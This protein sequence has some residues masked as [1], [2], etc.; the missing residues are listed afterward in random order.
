M[1]EISTIEKIRENDALLAHRAASGDSAARRQVAE[2][3]F[4]RVRTR[5]WYL[6]SSDRD[7]DDIIQNSLIE[8][9]KSLHNFRGESTL[10]TWADRIVIRTAMRFFNNRKQKDPVFLEDPEGVIE[11]KA[12]QLLSGSEIKAA[13]QKLLVKLPE[14]QRVVCVMRFAGEYSM[15]EIADITG[16]PLNTVKDR[17]KTGKAKL[18]RMIQSDPVLSHWVKESDYVD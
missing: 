12:F 4:E 10:D 7:M 13:L 11:C 6:A 15:E 2:K 1:T 5:V 14:N 16:A 8:I 18:L 17:L 9:L 3:L